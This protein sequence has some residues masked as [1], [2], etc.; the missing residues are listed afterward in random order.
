VWF[1]VPPSLAGKGR[2]QV[3]S[4]TGRREYITDAH[5]RIKLKLDKSLQAE[6]P[7][8]TVS[9][10]SYVIILTWIQPITGLSKVIRLPYAENARLKFPVRLCV[11]W[12]SRSE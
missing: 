7:E 8:V 4:A 6:N 12:A 9:H 10:Q 11:G 5:G 2:L 3:L 1:C